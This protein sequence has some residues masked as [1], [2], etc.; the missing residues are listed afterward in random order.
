MNQQYLEAMAGKK[1]L[2]CADFMP[3]SFWSWL[4]GARLTRSY[5]PSLVPLSLKVA[6]QCATI[7]GLWG[8]SIALG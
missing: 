3:E 2:K 8:F 5:L 6:S 1:I 4:W 7:T